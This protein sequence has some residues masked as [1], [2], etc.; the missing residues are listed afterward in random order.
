M[1]IISWNASNAHFPQKIHKYASRTSAETCRRQCW[2]LSFFLHYL[3]RIRCSKCNLWLK[4]NSWIYWQLASYS[5]F[6][7][8]GSRK[9]LMPARYTVKQ[10]VLIMSNRSSEGRRGERDGKGECGQTR[11]QIG[12]Q[13]SGLLKKTKKKSHDFPKIVV[14]ITWTFAYN[15]LPASRSKVML[16]RCMPYLAVQRNRPKKIAPVY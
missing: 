14:K 7:K 3:L 5:D 9:K 6:Q 2:P 13:T 4:V 8:Y 10:F 11:R 12:G 1:A 15:R 16:R